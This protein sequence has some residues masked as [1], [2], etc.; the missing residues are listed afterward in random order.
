MYNSQEFQN[1][2]KKFRTDVPI[3]D[4]YE[5]FAKMNPK[6]EYKTIGSMKNTSPKDSGVKDYYTRDEAL[7][8]TRQD[9]DKNPALYKAVQAS[10]SKW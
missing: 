6:K 7:Q 10:M 3:T 8:F 9:F 1:F 2:A 4:I 5:D